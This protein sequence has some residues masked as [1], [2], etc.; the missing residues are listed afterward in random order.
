MALQDQNL[1]LSSAQAVTATAQSTNAYDLLTGNTLAV[2]TGA[3]STNSIIGNAS[4]FGE[5]LGLGRSKGTPQIEVFSGAG[6]PGAAT[7]L[8]IQAQGAP[9]AGTG[10]TSGVAYKVYAQ[11]GAIPLASVLA[12]SRLGTLD[13]PRRETRAALPR[14]IALNYVV[15]GANFTNLTLTSYIN[16]GSNSAQDTLGQYPSNY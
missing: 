15:A 10:N 1:V 2:A 13:L 5:D 4:V 12:S 16:I 7:S 11:T 6:N 14:F 8:T 3:Y 9:D